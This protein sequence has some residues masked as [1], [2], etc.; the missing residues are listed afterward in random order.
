MI[1]LRNWG[2]SGIRG[3]VFDSYTNHETRNASILGHDLEPSWSNRLHHKKWG[4]TSPDGD[5]DCWNMFCITE[6]WSSHKWSLGKCLLSLSANMLWIYG[7]CIGKLGIWWWIHWFPHVCW[8]STLLSCCST[9]LEHACMHACM[10]QMND[11]N[12]LQD[13]CTA[14]SSSV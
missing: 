5:H 11:R 2:N 7:S 8:C 10:Q 6:S 9:W 4:R 14:C 12:R 13:S 1:F 3:K